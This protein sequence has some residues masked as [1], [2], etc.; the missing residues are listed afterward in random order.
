MR[1]VALPLRYLTTASG[2]VNL[3]MP[4]I[5]VS[6]QIDPLAIIATDQVIAHGTSHDDIE[7]TGSQAAED[8]ATS[9]G[10]GGGLWGGLTGLVIGI[11]VLVIPG[12]GAV[13]AGRVLATAFDVAGGTAVA[14]AGVGAAAGDYLAP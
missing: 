1:R 14:G 10:V 2:K 4:G 9:G 7:E 8:A 5:V 3:T 6:T 13:V 11:G 12:V